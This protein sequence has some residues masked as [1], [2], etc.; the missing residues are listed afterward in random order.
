[1]HGQ[2]RRRVTVAPDQNGGDVLRTPTHRDVALQRCQMPACSKY[3]AWVPSFDE[4]GDEIARRY[5]A[6]LDG[7]I[8]EDGDSLRTG[9]A[10]FAEFC[11]EQLPYSAPDGIDQGYFD[12]SGGSRGSEALVVLFSRE[13]QVQSNGIEYGILGMS[14]EWFFDRVPEASG[15]QVDFFCAAGDDMPSEGDQILSREGWLSA[16]LTAPELAGVLDRAPVLRQI[17]FGGS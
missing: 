11:E 8:A 10:A 15:I 6:V 4:I 17:G 2:R 13:L 14:S 3:D 1:V 9:I 7:H 5:Q 12:A 16:V